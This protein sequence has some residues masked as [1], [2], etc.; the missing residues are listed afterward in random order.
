VPAL[1]GRRHH[2]GIDDLS[3]HGQITALLEHRIEPGESRSMAGFR[4]AFAEQPNRGGIGHNPIQP[5]PK[6]ALKGQAISI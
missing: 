5:E 6:K 4:Q 3:A 2:G 1:F